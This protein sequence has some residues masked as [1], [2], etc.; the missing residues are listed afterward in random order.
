MVK[1]QLQKIYTYK[2]AFFSIIFYFDSSSIYNTN[3]YVGQSSGLHRL[4]YLHLQCSYKLIKVGY[5]ISSSRQKVKQMVFHA[6]ILCRIV[7][8]HLYFFGYP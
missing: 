8:I 4:E 1:I 2:G 6:G 5:N 3:K 7:K